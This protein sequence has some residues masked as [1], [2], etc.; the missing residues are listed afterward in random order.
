MSPITKTLKLNFYQGLMVSETALER[1]LAP[2]WHLI[3]PSLLSGV[4]VA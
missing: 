1:M 4:R 3:L 2:P